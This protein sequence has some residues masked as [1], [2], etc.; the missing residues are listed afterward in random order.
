MSRTKLLI[1]IDWFSPGY[2]AGGPVTSIVNLSKHLG[3]KLDLHILTSDTDYCASEPYPGIPVNTWHVGNAAV[4]CYLQKTILTFRLLLR[5]I[6]AAQCDIWYLNGIYSLYFSILPMLAAR[7]LHPRKII[8]APRGMLSRQT[9]S[10]KKYRKIAFLTLLRHIHWFRNVTFHATSEVEMKDIRKLFPGVPVV[11]LNNFPP[12]AAD[13]HSSDKISN[14]L[15]L[16]SMARI[17]PEKNTRFA[18]EVLGNCRRSVEFDLY[19]EISDLGYWNECRRIIECLPANVT[20]RYH[21]SLDPIALHR[22]L[23]HRDLLFLP[24]CGE[25]FGHAILESMLA[26]VP[27]LISDRTPWRNLEKAGVGWDLPL[28][29]PEEFARVIDK[30]AVMPPAEYEILRRKTALYARECSDAESLVRKYLQ[31]FEC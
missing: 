7:L 22:A 16:I 25:N 9:F 2:K 14:R 13:I 15:R 26:G 3:N 17:S 27:V 6:R 24:S 10:V 1:F 29:Q 11:C 5:M 19:G 30:C 21:G 12:L 4:V 23:E 18:L 28:E 20:V 31:L 8:V